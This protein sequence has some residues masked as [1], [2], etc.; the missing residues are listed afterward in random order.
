MTD[1]QLPESITDEGEIAIETPPEEEPPPQPDGLTIDTYNVA[2]LL[3]GVAKEFNLQIPVAM[4]LLDLVVTMRLSTMQLN[5]QR[6]AASDIFNQRR[7]LPE[8]EEPTDD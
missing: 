6:S 4:K 5:Q 2:T 3:R 8:P 7:P 1:E